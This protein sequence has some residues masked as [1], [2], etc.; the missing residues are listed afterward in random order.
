MTSVPG[1]R[2]PDDTNFIYNDFL[3]IGFQGLTVM[4][5][6]LLLTVFSLAIFAWAYMA[7]APR[8]AS[9]S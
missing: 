9:S 7:N 2:F 5:Y 1:A 3:P 8:E 6:D 4:S